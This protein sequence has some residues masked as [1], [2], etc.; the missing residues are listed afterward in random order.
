MA[1]SSFA[2]LVAPSLPVLWMQEAAT[3]L[4]PSGGAS[5]SSRWSS[6][7]PFDCKRLAIKAHRHGLVLSRSG[8]YWQQS[9]SSA[10]QEDEAPARV[11]RWTEFFG[12]AK[13]ASCCALTQEQITEFPASHFDLEGHF[14][15]NS[16]AGHK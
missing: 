13:S 10:K 12:K 7:V 9:S 11:Y 6:A 8:Q 16:S 2:W 3:T 1:Q 4:A 14:E 15:S 5:A